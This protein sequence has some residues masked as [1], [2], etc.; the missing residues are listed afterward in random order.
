MAKKLVV[1]VKPLSDYDYHDMISPNHPY[2][3]AMKVHLSRVDYELIECTGPVSVRNFNGHRI[4]V[5]ECKR[6]YIK[7]NLKDA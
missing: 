2:I 3:R 6:N 1:I 4:L 5:A 7:M